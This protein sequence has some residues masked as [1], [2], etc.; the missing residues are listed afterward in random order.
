M[1]GLIA[2]QVSFRFIVVFIAGLFVQSFDRL[3]HQPL[4]YSPDRVVNLESV[5]RRP[6]PAIYWE[7]VADHLRSINGVESVAIS[8]WSLMSGETAV[9]S[10][11]TH[12]TAS[13][14]FA[15]RFMLSP[16]GLTICGSR[17]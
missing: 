5:T 3:S 4:G 9:S 14:V 6:Q 1:H 15:D 17:F 8:S 11:A 16:D 7:A 2:I 12:G 13:E 10:I